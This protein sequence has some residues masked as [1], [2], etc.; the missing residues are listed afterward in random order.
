M[1][2]LLL[3]AI[4]LMVLMSFA[5][6]SCQSN[7]AKAT[8]ANAVEIC[9]LKELV[10]TCTGEVGKPCPINEGK[11]P[12]EECKPEAER[13]KVEQE[14]ALADIEHQVLLREKLIEE[15]DRQTNMALEYLK[16][17]EYSKG[18]EILMDLDTKFP[19]N[20]LINYNITCAYSLLG[21]KQEAIS[22]LHRTIQLGWMDWR[23]L[24]KDSDLDNIRN[25]EQYKKLREAVEIIF[26][27]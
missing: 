27:D 19:D 9:P 23:H 1:K 20:Y 2:K 14:K 15:F 8:S 21:N 4:A 13:I 24:D 25:E 5:V 6:V 11:G 26:P 18:L 22:S 3:L 12:C 17:K 16:E 7:S 10:K